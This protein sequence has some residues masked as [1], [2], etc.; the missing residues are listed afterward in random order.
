MESSF[1]KGYNWSNWSIERPEQLDTPCLAT[2]MQYSLPSIIISRIWF[3][4][5]RRYHFKMMGPES[6]RNFYY[7]RKLLK[8]RFPEIK[9][10][11]SIPIPQTGMTDLMDTIELARHFEP[12]SDYFFNRH[13]DAGKIRIFYWTSAGQRFVGIT[14]LT[15]DWNVAATLVRSS[16]I[17]VIL[18]GGLIPIMCLT[19]YC[20]FVR[21]GWTVVPEPMRW[22]RREIQ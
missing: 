21:P 7:Y 1:D 13:L 4:F 12:V 17:P 14:G 9:I 5:V 11:R 16:R 18:A 22:T 2:S 8:K 15:C 6:T 20:R 19:V 10:I 3:I